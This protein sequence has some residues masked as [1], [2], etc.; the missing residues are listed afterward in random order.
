M[1]T[2]I[3]FKMAVLF[4]PLNGSSEPFF[5]PMDRVNASKPYLMDRVEMVVSTV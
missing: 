2:V 1:G 3:K 4:S 5:Y